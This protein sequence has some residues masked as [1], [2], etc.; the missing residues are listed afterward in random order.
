MKQLKEL[1]QEVARRIDREFLVNGTTFATEDLETPIEPAIDLSA[2]SLV[3]D[4]AMRRF[5]RED[6]QASDAWLGPRFHAAL[7]LTRREAARRGIWRY[8]GVVAF[9]DYI[10]WRWPREKDG[11]SEPPALE[12]FIGPD[13]KHALARLWWMSELFR[14][15]ADYASATHA[16]GNQDVANN[17]FRMDIAHHRPVAL[18]AVKVLRLGE[19]GG[20]AVGREA[21]ALAK[22]V[23]IAAG[24][25]SIDLIA[26]DVALD[27]SAREGW[28]SESA[29]YDP[30]DFYDD[31]PAG[32]DDPTVSSDALDAMAAVMSE[33]L[34]TAPVRGRNESD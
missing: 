22:A 10:R 11:V 9:P 5:P 18:G 8:L 32:P 16:L 1:D 27:E 4:E 23:N 7:R 3:L 24:T 21:N 33:L 14:N 6:R 31:L 2:V 26:P 15:G 12:R 17:L 30:E 34:K 25:L 20:G 13:Y 29:S 19:S 28:A